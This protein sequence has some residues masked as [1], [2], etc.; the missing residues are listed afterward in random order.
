MTLSPNDR[1]VI[2][3]LVPFPVTGIADADLDD[4]LDAWLADDMA[5]AGIEPDFAEA[6]D[7]Q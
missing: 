6:E 3:S 5:S 2:R 1:K 7:L 4:I